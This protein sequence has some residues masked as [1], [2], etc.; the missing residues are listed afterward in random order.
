[1][2]MGLGT[3]CSCLWRRSFRNADFISIGRAL[4]G[5]DGWST[6]TS[7]DLRHGQ[8]DEDS[9]RGRITRFLHKY[10]E[11]IGTCSTVRASKRILTLKRASTLT[12]ISILI[13][14][15]KII[16]NINKNMN[17][18]EYAHPYQH[19]YSH[20]YQYQYQY[21]Y[22]YLYACTYIYKNIIKI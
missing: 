18:T 20:Q 22:K 17:M 1:M 8:V 2:M 3:S 4:L 9:C 7:R 12:L 11:Q 19:S 16:N 13:L 10:E 14:M 6:E 5:G 21:Q 15:L